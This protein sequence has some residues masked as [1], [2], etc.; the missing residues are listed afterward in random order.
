[1]SRSYSSVL[2]SMPMCQAQLNSTDFRSFAPAAGVY[3]SPSPAPRRPALVGGAV[4]NC[5]PNS[6]PSSW[7]L[8]RDGTH[9]V[10]ARAVA[11]PVHIVLVR[12]A[13][14]ISPASLVAAG[15][16]EHRA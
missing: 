1:M 14:V 16:A 4:L 2:R 11:A 6:D 8:D 7:A 3:S 13:M 12:K 9:I 15:V 10:S 5:G